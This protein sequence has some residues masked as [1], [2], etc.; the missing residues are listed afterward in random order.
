[1]NHS[2]LKLSAKKVITAANIVKSRFFGRYKK[3]ANGGEFNPVDA[4][5]I[6]AY[7]YSRPY[8]PQK[9]L[10]FAPFKN[11]Y[12]G[13]NGFVRACCRS[14]TY[15]WGSFPTQSIKEIW[16]GEKMLK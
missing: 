15:C 7:N 1:M 10:C 16:F 2:R 8:G 14:E 4:K 13:I 9:T 5:I 12:F 11:M 6:H 3:V